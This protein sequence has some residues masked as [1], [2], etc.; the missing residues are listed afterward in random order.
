MEKVYYHP[1]RNKYNSMPVFT[2]YYQHQAITYFLKVAE[3]LEPQM[4]ED[5][6]DLI[7]IFT[8]AEQ[9][10]EK[11][12]K[13]SRSFIDNW[14]IIEQANTNNNP[15][16]IELKNRLME[17]VQKYNL[18]DE[19]LSIKTYLEILLW[20]IP[21]KRDHPQK[22]EEWKNL[23]KRLGRKINE[24]PRNYINWSITDVIYFEDEDEYFRDNKKPQFGVD[25]EFPFIFSPDSWNV[26]QIKLSNLKPSAYHY[27]NILATYEMD[28]EFAL[29]GDKENIKGYIFGH[30]WDPRNET[31]NEFEKQI[32]E[33]YK[34]YKELYK[35]RTKEYMKKMAMLK[36][37]RKEIW[38]I[39]NGW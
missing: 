27:E 18:I 35:L 32:D 34:N 19:E 26:S 14:D 36:V 1:E 33:A 25:K 38:N 5:L 37:K 9:L 31:W 12:R 24:I 4:I 3:T 22:I 23:C 21:D 15:Y 10:H 17:W 2:N 20:A 8:E 7:P 13:K 39:F 28:V 6:D 11:Y 30:G 16:L 29:R